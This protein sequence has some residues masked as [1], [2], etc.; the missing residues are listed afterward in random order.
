MC[1]ATAYVVDPYRDYPTLLDDL[2]RLLKTEM[3]SSMRRQAIKVLGILGALDPYTHKVVQLIKGLVL[4]LKV[5]TKAVQD[6]TNMTTALSLPISKFDTSDPLSDIITWFN[7]ERCTLEEY[8]PALTIANL[9]AMVQDEAY[10]Q[11]YKEIATAIMTIFRSLDENYP[12]YVHQVGRNFAFRCFGF[13]G[14][15]SLDRSNKKL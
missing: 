2:L 13:T 14:C 5:F 3:S 15:P 6:S 1:R 10:T 12:Q 11:Y 9:M 8:Y 4:L 7:Y